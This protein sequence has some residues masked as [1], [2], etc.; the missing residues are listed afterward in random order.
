M[1]CQVPVNP[2]TAQMGPQTP[3]LRQRFKRPTS[4][5]EACG[6]LLLGPF[7][8][9]DSFYGTQWQTLLKELKVY[10]NTLSKWLFMSSSP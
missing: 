8:V 10:T 6:L 7:K 2:H 4:P 3:Q 9:G 1:L 5:R